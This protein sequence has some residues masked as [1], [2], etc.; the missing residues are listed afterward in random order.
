MNPKPLI[1]CSVFASGVAQIFLKQG[2]LNVQRNRDA[3]PG[4]LFRLALGAL[5]EG[6]VWLWGVTFVAATGLWLLGLQRVDLSYA[7]PLVS[8]SYVLVS[9]LASL[10]LHERV[11][12]D[13]WLAIVVIC[14]GVML[15]AGT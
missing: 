3:A 5:R 11:G 14:L 12:R 1:W 6:Y 8:F 4:S 15:I 9:I 7:Y 2:M 13:R 10:F